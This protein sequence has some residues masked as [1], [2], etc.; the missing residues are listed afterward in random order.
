MSETLI[1][2]PSRLSAKRLPGKPL[3][4]INGLSLINHVYKKAIASNIGDAYVVTG[5]IKIYKDVVNNG[6]KCILTK[7]KH[8]TGTL[9]R[10]TSYIHTIIHSILVP[11]SSI[12]QKF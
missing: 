3:L 10:V 6:G 12:H 2:I 9:E 7:Q 4:K 5:D 8:H 11:V 1:L